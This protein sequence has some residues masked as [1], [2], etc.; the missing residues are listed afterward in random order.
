MTETQETEVI[1]PWELPTDFDR[2]Y[3]RARSE[4]GWEVLGPA[5]YKSKVF[6]RFNRAKEAA[7]TLNRKE[8]ADT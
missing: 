5:Q 8:G 3:V 1:G 6:P 2:Y 7:D 4:G